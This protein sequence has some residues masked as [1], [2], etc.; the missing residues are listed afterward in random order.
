MMSLRTITIVLLLAFP[1][2]ALTYHNAPVNIDPAQDPAHVVN[3][4]CVVIEHSEFG[5][6]KVLCRDD[7]VAMIDERDPDQLCIIGI[8][9]FHDRGTIHAF[10]SKT[11]EREA[12]CNERGEYLAIPGVLLMDQMLK[13]GGKLILEQQEKRRRG[14]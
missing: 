8:V 1:A 6:A 7:L 12:R 13:N 5:S 3:H 10:I 9:H 2:S 14:V 11:W 4:E